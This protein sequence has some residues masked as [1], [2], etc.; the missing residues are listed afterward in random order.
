G[1]EDCGIRHRKEPRSLPDVE[2]VLNRISPERTAVLRD[3]MLGVEEPNVGL[4]RRP[5][6]SG[7]GAK[8]FDFVVVPRP[9][10]AR[11]RRRRTG[12]K[13]RCAGERKR[14]DLRKAW[15]QRIQERGRSR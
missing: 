8:R 5:Q 6:R 1:I 11:Q 2:T 7:Q 14:S 10:A 3:R 9:Y 4:L 13:L 15:E 12:A